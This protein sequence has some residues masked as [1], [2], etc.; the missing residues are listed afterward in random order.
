MVLE[1]CIGAE[2]GIVARVRG[3]QTADPALIYSCLCLHSGYANFFPSESLEY[4]SF[5][6]ALWPF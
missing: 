1:I 5:S 2:A 6:A 4:I 3:K